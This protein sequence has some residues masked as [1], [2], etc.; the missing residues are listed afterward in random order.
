MDHI[1]NLD[2][3]TGR[4]V[5]LAAT[6]REP[7]SPLA[8]ALLAAAHLFAEL[9][10]LN[11]LKD[12][13]RAATAPDAATR[14]AIRKAVD[15]AIRRG[16]A[17]LQAQA[18]D[19]DALTALMI[20]HGVERDYLALVDKSYRQSW[21]HARKAQEYAIGLTAKHPDRKDAWFTIGFS[22][23]L[24]SSVPF[25]FRPFMKMESADGNRRRAFANLEKAAEGGRYLRGFAQMIL[26]SAYRK[27]GRRAD[28]ERI[29][30]KLARD[31]PNNGA[32]R[33]E[34]AEPAGLE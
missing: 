26:A 5:A 19:A 13:A 10:R 12:N 24:I 1:Y 2:F 21:V 11:L 17:T 33:R 30:Q 7:S 8:P 31:Y 3:A 27:E 29:L 20:A 4:R 23:Y 32:I 14:T 28:A 25:V 34:L 15:E 9:D 22:D 18:N 16:E 6:E